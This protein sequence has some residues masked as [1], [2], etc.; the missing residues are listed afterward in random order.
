MFRGTHVSPALALS[1]N[2]QR[3]IT[4]KILMPEVWILYMTLDPLKLYPH[5]KFHFKSISWTWVICKIKSVSGKV[6]RTDRPTDRRTYGQTDDGEV[7]P[8][9]HLCLQQVTQK[10]G[11]LHTKHFVNVKHEMHTWT[12]YIIKGIEK[13]GVPP[14]K[15]ALYL[16]NF[17]CSFR[18]LSYVSKY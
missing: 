10:G 11:A 6:W 7:I 17:P 18:V 4:P 8:K 14:W 12:G 5:M 15:F 2:W 9:C 13:K 16:F 3:G 1:E